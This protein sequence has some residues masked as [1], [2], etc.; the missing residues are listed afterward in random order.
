MM[1]LSEAASLLPQGWPHSVNEEKDKKSIAESVIEKVL[2]Q[3]EREDREPTKWECD[4]LSNAMSAVLFGS[5]V[6]AVKNA[7]DCYLSKSEISKSE[8]WWAGSE[9]HSVRSLKM[10]LEKI[11]GYPPRFS[12]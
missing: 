9:E 1:N 5:Y 11:K 6:L 8:E 2:A 7:M 12:P 3:I 4:S 10:C